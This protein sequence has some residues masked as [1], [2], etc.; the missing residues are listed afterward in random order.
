[1]PCNVVLLIAFA[2]LF[3]NQSTSIYIKP[4][5]VLSIKTFTEKLCDEIKLFYILLN[6]KYLLVVFKKKSILT[7]VSLLQ[8]FFFSIN[9][10]I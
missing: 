3:F 6:I 2:T 5:Y 4:K 9:G 10:N 1:M 8:S 7:L